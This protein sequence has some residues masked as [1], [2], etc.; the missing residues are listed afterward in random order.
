MKTPPGISLTNLP[1]TPLFPQII[2]VATKGNEHKGITELITRLAL[3]GPFDLIVGGEWLPDH[4]SLRRSVRRYTVNVNEMLDHALLARA[5]TYLQFLDILERSNSQNELMLIL[6]FLHQFYNPDVELSLRQR[7][8]EKCCLRTQ[9][10][11]RS[12]FVIVLVEHLQ[13]E[14]YRQFLPI[15]ESVADI[16]LEA[17]EISPIEATQISLF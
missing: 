15:L 10:L 6:G 7:A 3:R 5:S 11:S 2:L 14:E 9:E 12:K 13:I 17:E 8:L 16:V 4:D 1:P